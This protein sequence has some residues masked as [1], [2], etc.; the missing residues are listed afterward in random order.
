MILQLHL[1][2]LV[3][4]AALIHAF[5]NALVKS[6]GDRAL[7]MTLI[8]F[9][10]AVIGG[11]AIFYTGLPDPAVWPYLLASVVLHNFYYLFLLLS[12]R[13]GDL[14]EVYPIARGC[15]PL[16]VVGLALVLAGEVPTEGALAG[17]VL[18][19]IGIISLTFARGKISRDGLKP[20]GLALVTGTLIA[21]YTVVDG[22]GIRSGASPWPYI[23]WLNFLEGVPI[24][25][26]AL[27]RRSRQIQ[28]F[29]AA[30]WKPGVLGGSLALLAYAAAL[31]ALNQ[32][33]MA[34][35]SALRETSVLFATLIGAIVLKEG[36]GWRRMAAALLIT[37]GIIILQVFG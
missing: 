22:L 20:I 9:T 34:H 2:F 15:S 32:G 33:A 1:V 18:V 27:S 37:S 6:A 23:A 12:Y 14:S 25:L 28:P 24:T 29:L 4:L 13:V 10:G 36:F 11:I 19:S 30:N 8:H 17:I 5:W 21:S 31:Y 7:T 16:L 3:L 26:W 35:V